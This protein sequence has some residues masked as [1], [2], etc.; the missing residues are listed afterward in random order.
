VRFFQTAARF[1]TFKQ[2]AVELHVTQGAVRQYPNE[3]A[4]RP[5][6]QA[7][8]GWLH[9]QAVASRTLGIQVGAGN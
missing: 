4:T 9:E 7:V 2:A 1:L 6:M 5:A 8:I 3:L